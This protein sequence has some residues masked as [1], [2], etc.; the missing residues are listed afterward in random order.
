MCSLVRITTFTRFVLRAV[1]KEMGEITQILP[2]VVTTQQ[3]SLV[4][5]KKLLAIAVSCITYL[6][7]LF[8]EKAY[9]SKYVEEQKVMILREEKSCPGASQIVQWLYGCFDALQKKYLRMVVLSI[10]TD[11]ENPQKVTECYQFKI[12]YTE[13]GPEVDFESHTNRKM[14]TMG[15]GDTRKASILLVRKLYTLMQNLGPLPDKVFLNMKLSYYDE[16]TPQD[17]QPPGFKDADSSMLFEKEPVHLTMGN[18]VTPFHTLKVDVITEKER[19][20]KIDNEELEC[21]EKCTRKMAEETHAFI[22]KILPAVENHSPFEMDKNKN[23]IDM[24]GANL[25]CQEN[26]KIIN[27][28]LDYSKH[29]KRDC[30]VRK[31]ADVETAVRRTRSGRVVCPPSNFVFPCSQEEA[32]IPKRRKFS[33]PK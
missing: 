22:N 29:S 6:R 13:N 25:S 3:Q 21:E 12:Q 15:F 18:V 5:V 16:V 33:E 28:R 9:G 27:N 10:Y 2:N 23:Q 24:P 31:M 11:P 20:E 8:P 1:F 17:Y 4:V 7:G 26:E 30:Q 14:V 19:L 32:V